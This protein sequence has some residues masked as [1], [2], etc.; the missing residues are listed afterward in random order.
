MQMGV[1]I[2]GEA[3]HGSSSLEK[4]PFE[5]NKTI[6]LVWKCLPLVC[7]I[8]AIYSQTCAGLLLGS[9]M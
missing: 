9:L 1:A 6:P 7:T 4:I 5:K 3:A 2:L 8:L